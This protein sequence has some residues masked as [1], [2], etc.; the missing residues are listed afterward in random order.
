MSG[1]GALTNLEFDH[2]NLIVDGN[3]DEFV[4]IEA[5]IGVTAAEIARPDLPD[6]IAA[7]FSM[8]GADAALAG[9]MREAALF[10]DCIERAH[11][12]WTERAKAH[13]RDVED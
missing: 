13:R 10:R 5:A 1:L 2:L 9:I 4:R 7:L 12:I 11:R 6:Q 3:A 8:I